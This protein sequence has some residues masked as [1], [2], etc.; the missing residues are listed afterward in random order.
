L[1]FMVYHVYWAS[2]FCFVASTI[3]LIY[4]AFHKYLRSD[5]CG[6]LTSRFPPQHPHMHPS[7]IQPAGH[8][9]ETHGLSYM[10]S[11][12]LTGLGS[13]HEQST[14]AKHERPRTTDIRDAPGTGQGNL[15]D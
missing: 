4:R 11:H 10:F 12:F 14:T 13:Y 7:R 5:P 2:V 8:P 9:S 3:D 6:A 15:E 1:C